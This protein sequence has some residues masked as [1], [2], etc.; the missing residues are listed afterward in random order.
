ME[1]EQKTTSNFDEIKKSAGIAIN[2]EKYEQTLKLD[3]GKMNYQ[4]LEK[5]DRKTDIRRLLEDRVRFAIQLNAAQ[6]A[7]SKILNTKLNMN[8]SKEIDNIY[9]FRGTF[10]A[11]NP[12]RFFFNY[13]FNYSGKF[14]GETYDC[15]IY[16]IRELSFTSFWEKIRAVSWVDVR[17]EFIEQANL[18]YPLY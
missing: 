10:T 14:K 4:T 18:K 16:E 5:N 7:K 3:K 1:P 13:P 8:Y 17:H 11:E 15:N 6:R 2:D 12:L 9:T